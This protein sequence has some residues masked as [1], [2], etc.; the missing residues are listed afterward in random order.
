MARV[1]PGRRGVAVLAVLVLP[2]LARGQGREPAGTPTHLGPVVLLQPGMATA[3]FVSAPSGEPSTTGFAL[4]VSA[5]VPSGQR[6]LTLVVGASVTPFGSSGAS[7]RNTNT[8]MLFV[9]NVFPVLEARRTAG[10]LSVDAPLLLTYTEGGGGPSNQRVY[11]RD[12]VGE[13]A[14]TVHMGRKLLGGFGGALS[15]LRLYGLL[16]QNLTPNRT[17]EG[18]MDRFNPVAYYGV[19]VPLGT[20]RDSP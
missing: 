8:P 1:I 16:D 10:W 19:T 15:R 6:W 7:R 18:K 11:G 2:A 13:L 17:F 5:L 3:D 9:G 4:R 12:V 14:V 20:G